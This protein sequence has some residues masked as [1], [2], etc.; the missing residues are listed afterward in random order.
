VDLVGEWLVEMENGFAGRR[1][2]GIRV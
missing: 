2:E 1:S